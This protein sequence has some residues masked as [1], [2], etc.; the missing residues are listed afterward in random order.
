MKDALTVVMNVS[1]I[2]TATRTGELSKVL[3]ICP[4]SGQ[5]IICLVHDARSSDS[6][7]GVWQLFLTVNTIPDANKLVR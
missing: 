1:Y 4:T 6:S 5:V 7:S 3:N 2:L